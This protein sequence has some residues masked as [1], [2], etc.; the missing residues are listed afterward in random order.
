MACSDV[1]YTYNNDNRLTKAD[2]ATG[3]DYSYTYD[4]VGN[5]TKE[6]NGTAT[7]YGYDRA[8]EL[9]WQGPTNG[10]NLARAC[11]STP[12]GDTRVYQDPLAIRPELTP[13]P[14][15]MTTSPATTVTS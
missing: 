9:C 6:D 4:N 1:D 2:A 10:T 11:P 3:T 14:V 13:I 7:Y 5:V 15:A 12:G 8:G